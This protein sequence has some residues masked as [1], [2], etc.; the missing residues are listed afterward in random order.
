LFIILSGIKSAK[1]TIS[2]LLGQAPDAE[3]VKSIEDTVLAYPE[4]IGIHDLVVHD[5]G[6]SRRMI[7]LHAE[8]RGDGDMFLLHDVIDSAEMEI[9]DRFGCV[10]TIHMDPIEASDSETAKTKQE[11]SEKLLEIDP[12]ITIHDFRM[13]SGPT[14][15]KLIFDAVVPA[16]F[17]LSDDVLN[18]KICHLI[19][20]TWPDRYAVVTID[21]SLT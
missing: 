16:D 21:H 11:I 10:A 7:S 3:F 8:V 14:H 20:F 9:K 6:P 2:P 19:H 12:S 1:D 5:Y 15:T 17:H 4:I 13:V 18:Y